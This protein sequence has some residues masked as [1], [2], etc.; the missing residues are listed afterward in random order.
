MKKKIST[1]TVFMNI[2]EK[3]LNNIL[4]DQTQSL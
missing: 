1:S 3:L 2:D 4:A